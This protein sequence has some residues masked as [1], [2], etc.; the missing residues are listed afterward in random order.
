MIR[1]LSTVAVLC[2]FVWGMTAPGSAQGETLTLERALEIAFENSPDILQTE[3][4]LTQRRELLKAQQAA[5]KS[6]LSLRLNPFSYSKNRTFDDLVNEWNSTKTKSSQ[7]T[8]TVS[9]PIKETDGTL[10]LINQLSWRESSSEYQ[11]NRI[12]KSFNNNLYLSYTQPLFTYNRTKMELSELELSLENALYTYTIQKLSLENQVTQS[13]YSLY[14][15]KMALD[16][17]KEELKNQQLSHDIISRKVE[18]GLSAREELFQAELNLANSELNV[19]NQEESLDNMFD[20]FKVLLGISI[21]DE[22]DVE[23]SVTYNKVDVDLQ[24]AL[25]NAL[26]ERLELRQSEISIQNAMHEL[27]RTAAQNEFSGDLTLTYGLIGTD[28]DIGNIYDSPTEQNEVGVT[29][30]IPLWD[31]G[32]NKSRV[33]ASQIDIDRQKL[34]LED[35]RTGIIL[36]IRRAHRSLKKLETQISIA[37]QN[38]RNAQ[39]TYDIN[40]ERYEN[41]DL[42]SMD[43]NLYQTQLSESKNGLVETILNYKLALLDMKILSLWDFESNKQVLPETLE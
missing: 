29:F 24:R 22:I 25:D 5:L 2:V 13:F 10:Q 38:V 30:N 41:G 34:L 37:E 1:N 8:F 4:T 33:K 28:E 42:T 19:Q 17:S 16:I 6:N 36:A 18:A 14:Q 21:Y 15:A 35:E 20:D 31:W 12:N 3:M 40:L 11:D 26:D 27:T 7:T 9:Q 23:T 32:E 39:M 43:L